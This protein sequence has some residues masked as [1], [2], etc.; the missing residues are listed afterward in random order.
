MTGCL[1]KSH[2]VVRC[3]YSDLLFAV[4]CD[5]AASPTQ[6]KNPQSNLSE[7]TVKWIAHTDS[8]R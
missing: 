8:R 3:L 5:I 2:A 6:N 7:L 4:C 1:R